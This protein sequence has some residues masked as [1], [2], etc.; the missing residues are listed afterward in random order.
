M[1]WSSCLEPVPPIF[2]EPGGAFFSASTNSFD[3][4][5]GLVGIHPQHEL[6]E[7][8]HRDRS[9]ILPVERDAGRE[10]RGEQ[11][12]QRDDDLV[13]IAGRRLHVEEAFAAGTAG[14]VD[15]DHR[16]LHQI[17]LGHDPLDRARHLIGATAGAGRNDEFHGP[18]RL[19]RRMRRQRDAT[20]AQSGKRSSSNIRFRIFHMRSSPIDKI[21][22]VCAG[23]DSVATSWAGIHATNSLCPPDPV[24]LQG[25]HIERSL[26]RE[27]FIITST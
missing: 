13:R 23:F 7:R 12:R 10:R 20:R 21:A 11:V 15:H 19:P 6:V 22:P 24:E 16:L 25:T 1:I 4:L 3:V 2:I 26:K 14:L 8:Q 17:V 18:R 9:E 5:V 27:L